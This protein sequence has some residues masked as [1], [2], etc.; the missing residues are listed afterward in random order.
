MNKTGISYLD[1][2]WNPIHGC[3]PI[4]AGCKN[5]WANTMAKR[6]AG[7]GV[8]GY[9]KQNPFKVTLHPDRLDEPLSVKKPSRIGVAFMG[10]L[11]HKDV[12]FEY[13]HMVW[14]KMFQCPHHTFLILTKRLQRLK[15]FVRA[16]HKNTI[17]KHLWLGTSIEDQATADTRILELL[18]IPAAVRY[19]S[20]EPMLG[21]VDLSGYLGKA[22]NGM[23]ERQEEYTYNFGINWVILGAESGPN[24]R[25]CKLEW[26]VDVVN[27]CKSA[28]VP[29]YVKQI[30]LG[31]KVI[32]DISQ[33]PPELQIRE[34]PNV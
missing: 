19:L 13:M 21:P 6:L 27:Q 32:E 23:S 12:P 9:D 17:S 28:G 33:F 25:P 7:M 8:D 15:D 22:F 1:Y 31:G 4:S 29:V 18:Q 2:T 5:C 20:I 11:F 14:R 10:D 34:Y 26:M 24:R 30:D 16:Y 3:S